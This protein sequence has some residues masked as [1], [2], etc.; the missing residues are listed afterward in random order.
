MCRGGKKQKGGDGKDGL[1]AAFG[2]C[3]VGWWWSLCF[4][5]E[6]HL[7]ARAWRRLLD[8]LN[9]GIEAGPPAPGILVRAAGVSSRGDYFKQ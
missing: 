7:R 2:W 9:L 8:L 5:L 3:F 1:V 6:L 4:C